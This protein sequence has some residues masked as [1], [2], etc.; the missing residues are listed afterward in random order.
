VKEAPAKTVEEVAP[1][2]EDMQPGG[3]PI[4]KVQIAASS[5]QLAPDAP[6]FMG[7]KG[8][9][10]YAENGMFKYTIGASPD[11]DEINR[12]RKTVLDAFPQAFII[13]FR[14]GYKM[15]ISEAVREYRKNK[16]THR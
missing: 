15:N 16:A 7:V 2:P 14:D 13:A 12:L 6:Q 1:V 8:V 4:F 3:R 10:M 9:E 11:F 5:L